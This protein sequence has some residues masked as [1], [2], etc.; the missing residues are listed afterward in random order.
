MNTNNNVF[1]LSRKVWC[2][3][4]SFEK[5]KALLINGDQEKHELFTTEYL[6]GQFAYYESTSRDEVNRRVFKNELNFLK[7]LGVEF[8]QEKALTVCE[9]LKCMLDNEAAVLKWY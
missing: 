8:D 6:A 4:S 5:L 7:E 9:H 2:L 3:C 1:I